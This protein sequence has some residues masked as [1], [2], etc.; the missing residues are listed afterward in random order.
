MVTAVQCASDSVIN[1][2]RC[3]YFPILVSIAE[4][5]TGSTTCLRDGEKSTLG[6]Q[7]LDSSISERYCDIFH[8]M[9][10]LY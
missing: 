5:V 8:L 4:L 7:S 10:L 3:I 2:A 9:E 1:I 6:L